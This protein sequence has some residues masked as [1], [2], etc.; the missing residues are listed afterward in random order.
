MYK[1]LWVKLSVPQMA[2]QMGAE[3][4]MGLELR[5]ALNLVPD[6]ASY[7]AQVMATWSSAILW[8]LESVLKKASC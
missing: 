2:V 3:R 4:G 5:T 8:D 1:L 6:L 7:L